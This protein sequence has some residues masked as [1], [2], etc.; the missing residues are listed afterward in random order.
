MSADLASEIWSLEALSG[1]QLSARIEALL[2]EH[3]LFAEAHGGGSRKEQVSYHVF[4]GQL[5]ARH[6]ET[7]FREQALAQFSSAVKLDP[8]RA[9]VWFELGRLVVN[10]DKAQ[11]LEYFDRCISLNLPAFRRA[12]VMSLREKA[13][14]LRNQKWAKEAVS[15]D[16]SD[17]ESWYVL[18]T[19]ALV[20]M[21]LNSALKAFRQCER[22]GMSMP[23][24]PEL[25]YN[26]GMIMMYL[27]NYTEA[28]ALFQKS[29]LP[30]GMDAS[31]EC[32]SRVTQILR[33]LDKVCRSKSG[34]ASNLP[35]SAHPVLA[36]ALSATAPTA[37]T[38]TKTL[39]S[40][41]SSPPLS[42]SS[43]SLLSMPTSHPT[44][45]SLPSAAASDTLSS[46]AASRQGDAEEFSGAGRVVVLAS[47][48]ES[49]P[50]SFIVE[51]SPPPATAPGSRGA[52]GTP[53]ASSLSVPSASTAALSSHSTRSGACA[54][55]PLV[56]V[57][58]LYNVHPRDV[59]DGC[60]I[61]V[62]DFDRCSRKVQV[63][64]PDA[65]EYVTWQVDNTGSNVIV[66]GQPVRL[67]PPQTSVNRS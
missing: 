7:Q 22:L 49:C 66:N 29:A 9:D 8:S 45:V 67:V 54:E 53:A 44:A 43:S 61:Q 34:A 51:Y 36:P 56:A 25:F 37:S 15:M 46:S 62:K 14:I 3:P 2:R 17:P 30:I 1:K 60:S 35:A 64:L 28:I 57:L 65:G 10:Q 20:R 47:G 21:D 27:E 19:V 39:S 55:K 5:L 26:E 11:A 12:H 59:P 52:D 13:R 40:S 24:D 58:S 16:V 50:L 41:S 38:T 42:S 32:V 18:G 6:P 63:A 48:S 4:R 23:K 31:K 33:Q